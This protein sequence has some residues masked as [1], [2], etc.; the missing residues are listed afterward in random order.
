MPKR[1]TLADVAERAGVSRTAVSLILNDRPG[2][3]LSAEAA[4]RVRTAA[5]ELNYRP[6]LAAQSL[7]IG[8]T[9][10]IGFI[11]DDVAITRYA[12]AMIRGALDV[13]DHHAHTMLIA[14]T[15][16]DSDR[17]S[18]ALDAMLDRQADGV[19][20]GS[21]AA[22]RIEVP[23]LPGD[24]PVV[25]LNATSAKNYPRVLPA[26]HEAGYRMARVLLDRGHRRIAIIGKPT[27]DPSDPRVS[28]TLGDRFAGIQ[29]AFAAFDIDPSVVID[30]DLWE[31]QRGYQAAQMLLDSGADVTALLALND[32]L[33]FGAYQAFQ[34]RGRRIPADI[35]IAS[36]DDDVI[37][38]YL[39]P[40]LTTAQIPYEEMGRQAMTMLLL[41]H[42]VAGQERLVPMPIKIR[43]SVLT[44]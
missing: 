36:F 25:L 34:E 29:E 22:R 19:I 1:V 7:R 43:E 32:R 37:A 13:A 44:V 21:M 20:F 9:R 10:T 2:T 23:P 35:S 27:R 11:S 40:G 3:R 6:N 14:E 4:E 39:R 12:S 28:A 41:E 42:A 24:L 38:S 8:K 5:A 31:P 16:A 17:V 26:E 30:E 18:K 33:A 15:G